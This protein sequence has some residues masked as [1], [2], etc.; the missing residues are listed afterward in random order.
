M[1]AGTPITRATSAAAAF[2]P[3]ISKCSEKT[4]K[5]N[6][7]GSCSLDLPKLSSDGRNAIR[8]AAYARFQDRR[9]GVR[10]WVASVHLDSR[11]SSNRT[12]EHAYEALRARQIKAV[13]DRLARLNTTGDKVIVAG[14]RDVV[15]VRYRTWLAP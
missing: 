4:G 5:R 6:Y 7:S 2:R 12:K 1:V 10:L 9:T 3:S 13:T 11:H 8:S 14:D 15:S